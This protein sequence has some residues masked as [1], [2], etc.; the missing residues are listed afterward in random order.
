[1]FKVILPSYWIWLDKSYHQIARDVISLSEKLKA[2]YEILTFLQRCK[3]N[4]LVLDGVSHCFDISLKI[5][6]SASLDQFLTKSKRNLLSILIRS[7]YSEINDINRCLKE[8]KS[9]LSDERELNSCPSS[10]WQRKRLKKDQR[11]L[12]STSSTNWKMYGEL[13]E[14]THP[15]STPDNCKTTDNTA[16]RVTVIGDIKVTKPALQ[17]LCTGPKFAISPHFSREELQHTV[18]TEVAALAYATRWQS[19]YSLPPQNKQ[20]TSTAVTEQTLPA[21][22]SAVTGKSHPVT[23]Q[24][25]KRRSKIYKR[26]PTDHWEMWCS[27]KLEPPSH[28]TYGSQRTE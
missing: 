3:R 28:R 20:S 4:Y 27:R 24:W 14:G 17:A 12:P 1:M 19:A 16:D 2:T 13:P 6:N 18:Q 11:E 7:K 9:K 25:L 26:H 15:C 22:P 8:R 23:T 5:K 10:L 21:C